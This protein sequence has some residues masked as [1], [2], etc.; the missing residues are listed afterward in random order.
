MVDSNKRSKVVG[1]FIRKQREALGMSQKALGQLF[2]PPVT[3]Q[4][5]SNVERG[6]TPLPP[7]HIPV[8]AKF[9]ATTEME[10]MA[11]L[12]KEYALK[13]TGRL[14]RSGTSPEEGGFSVLLVKATE[15]DFLKS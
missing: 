6:V 14:G 2:S 10:I 1:E 11:L 8:L 15:S 9:L 12:E 13:L 7:V 4:F 3:T 5:I